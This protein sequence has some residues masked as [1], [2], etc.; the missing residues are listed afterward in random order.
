MAD[1]N[2]E[3]NEPR[4]SG[5]PESGPPKPSPRVSRGALSWVIIF[6][7]ALVFLILLRQSGNDTQEISINVFWTHVENKAV[8]SIVIK[9]A[10][11]S[12]KLKAP[13]PDWPSEGSSSLAPIRGPLTTTKTSARR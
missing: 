4:N 11:I 6:G 1:Q 12:G 10:S 9:E 7:L 5:G 2:P 13:Q 3:S 8:K